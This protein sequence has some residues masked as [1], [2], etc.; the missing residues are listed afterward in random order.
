[1][2]RG[3]GKQQAE[4]SSFPKPEIPKPT[5]PMSRCPCTEMNLKH[6]SEVEPPARGFQLLRIYS[7]SDLAAA[8]LAGD[9]A[10]VWPGASRLE[11]VQSSNRRV[12]ILGIGLWILSVY[13]F[14]RARTE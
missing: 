12:S 1:M 10:I 11:E 3:T 5:S 4:I 9:G 7:P 8:L 14:F 2:F 13:V 6:T